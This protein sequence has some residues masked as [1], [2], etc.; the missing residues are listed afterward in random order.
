MRGDKKKRAKNIW[1][2]TRWRVCTCAFAVRA[3]ERSSPARVAS[4][5]AAGLLAHL[6]EAGADGAATAAA[7]DAAVEPAPERARV[8]G[9]RAEARPGARRLL[10]R[11]RPRRDAHGGGCLVRG[12]AVLLL[13]RRRA[14]GVEEQGLLLRHRDL[15]DR[16]RPVQLQMMIPHGRSNT[17]LTSGGVLDWFAGLCP[18]TNRFRHIY[19]L[20]INQTSKNRIKKKATNTLL[21]TYKSKHKKNKRNKKT[22]IKDLKLLT[23]NI[24]EINNV[25]SWLNY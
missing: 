2:C 19:K 15:L 24:F 5:Y 14:G 7:A 4:S 3:Y 9:R 23:L 12:G 18:L 22:G 6:V 1:P 21:H 10:I 13:P 8:Q 11:G 20:K 17:L 25:W 16:R